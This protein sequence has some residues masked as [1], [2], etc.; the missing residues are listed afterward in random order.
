MG[1]INFGYV[2]GYLWVTFGVFFPE[3]PEHVLMRNWG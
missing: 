2:Q 3:K 1:N